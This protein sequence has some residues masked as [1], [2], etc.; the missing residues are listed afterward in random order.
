MDEWFG[1]S[2]EGHANFTQTRCFIGTRPFPLVDEPVLEVRNPRVFRTHAI[3]EVEFCI[4]TVSKLRQTS[5]SS[6]STACTLLRACALLS[7]AHGSPVSSTPCHPLVRS[8]IAE[9]KLPR[10]IRTCPGFSEFSD[11][12]KHD[13]TVATMASGRAPSMRGV[14]T[15]LPRSEGFSTVRWT[16]RGEARPPRGA[17]WTVRASLSSNDFRPGVTI[18]LDGAPWR[19][20]GA[21]SRALPRGSNGA[22]RSTW[23]RKKEACRAQHGSTWLV[24]RPAAVPP[25]DPAHNTLLRRRGGNDGGPAS[26]HSTVGAQRK[27]CGDLGVARARRPRRMPT[28]CP[29]RERGS[30]AAR[31]VCSMTEHAATCSFA[32]APCTRSQPWS[33]TRCRARTCRGE[34]APMPLGNG[35]ALLAIWTA[36]RNA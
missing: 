5:P 21:L 36:W 19:V 10:G 31:A 12:P 11:G 33:R 30:Q 25:A 27:G 1:F 18:E 32:K 23:K 17:S 9:K 28:S 29:G 7:H 15:R 34:Y 14:C 4:P 22:D 16:R 3:D 20:Q 13:V 6:I 35:G 8:T 26:M 24:G 2:R